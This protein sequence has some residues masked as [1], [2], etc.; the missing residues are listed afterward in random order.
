MQILIDQLQANRTLTSL[1]YDRLLR[2]LSDRRDRQIMMEEQQPQPGRGGAG[3]AGSQPS[4]Y[5]HHGNNIII[6]F[7]FLLNQG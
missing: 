4:S 5:H 7:F 1:E 2:Y 3:L 6:C